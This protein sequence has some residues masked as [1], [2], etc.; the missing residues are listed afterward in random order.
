M[1]ARA[2]E[3]FPARPVTWS[4]VRQHSPDIMIAAASPAEVERG[5]F[6][7]VLGEIHLAT[8]LAGSCGSDGWHA[9]PSAM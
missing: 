6:L 5:N 9:V 7:L 2:A 1:S 3:C 4:G 8:N